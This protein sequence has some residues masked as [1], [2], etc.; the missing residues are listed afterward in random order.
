MQQ[1]RLQLGEQASRTVALRAVE[2]L[3]LRLEDLGQVADGAAAGD[4]HRRGRAIKAVAEQ[5]GLDTLVMVVDDVLAC[6]ASGDPV[7]LAA[8]RA[9]LQRIGWRS[10][11][12][13]RAMLG[14]SG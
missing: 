10:L 11:G 9:R 7:A 8:T 4:M 5:I 14:Q 1:L 6:H 3:A 12:E 2:D 13:I